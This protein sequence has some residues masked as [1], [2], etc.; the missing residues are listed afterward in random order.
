M[1]VQSSIMWQPEPQENLVYSNPVKEG[2]KLEQQNCFG[3]CEKCKGP[4]VGA[5]FCTECRGVIEV[6]CL[7]CGERIWYDAHEFC[8]C[9]LELLVP[10]TKFTRW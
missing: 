7:Y 4:L 10:Q 2:K 9:Q 5:S 1:I 8:Y 6:S 3:D